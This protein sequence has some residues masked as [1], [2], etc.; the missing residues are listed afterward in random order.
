MGLNFQAISDQCWAKSQCSDNETEKWCWL[1][2]A[3]HYWHLELWRGLHPKSFEVGTGKKVYDKTRFEEY[4][5][6][7]T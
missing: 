1:L 4:W 2:H 6:A 5:R 3:T 7:I